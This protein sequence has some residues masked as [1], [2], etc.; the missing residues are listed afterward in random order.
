MNLPAVFGL[1]PVLAVLAAL[2][3]VIGVMGVNLRLARSAA[4]EAKAGT[5]AAA[6][7]ASAAITERDAW[8]SKADDALAA[9]RAMD[10]VLDQMQTAADESRRMAQEAAQRAAASVAAA[11]REEAQAERALAEFQRMFGKR[12]PDCDTALKS[13]D[14]VCP[15]WRY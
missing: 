9:N 7:M 4:E 15:A 3:L 6:A 13:L 14:R 2:L 8:K 11:Q 1:K 5:Q 12:P 10:V